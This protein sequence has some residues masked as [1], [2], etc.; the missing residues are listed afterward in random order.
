MAVRSQVAVP[1]YAE[2]EQSAPAHRCSGSGH[3][4]PHV[5]PAML[6]EYSYHRKH[7]RWESPSG[8]VHWP[9]PV[10]AVYFV[11]QAD[12]LRSD[13]LGAGLQSVDKTARAAA[14]S[15]LKHPHAPDPE[16]EGAQA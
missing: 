12:L 3:T 11:S 8:S 15:A 1:E 7:L 13:G 6:A 10:Q 14:N 9:N 5:L 2:Y 16:A 4:P